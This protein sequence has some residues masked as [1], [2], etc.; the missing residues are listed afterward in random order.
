MDKELGRAQNN[1]DHEWLIV[2][3]LEVREKKRSLSPTKEIPASAESAAQESPVK[4]SKPLEA[5]DFFVNKLKN[6]A[7]EVQG[8][9]T[10]YLPSFDSPIF[11]NFFNV[12]KHDIEKLE[13]K[14]DSIHSLLN[15]PSE[16]FS[17]NAQIISLHPQ[18]NLI[19][20]VE[21]NTPK[22]IKIFDKSTNQINSTFNIL[23]T[24]SIQQIQFLN[25][26]SLLVIATE[27]NNE[28]PDLFFVEFTNG[29]TKKINNNDLEKIGGYIETNA[30]ASAIILNRTYFKVFHT[31]DKSLDYSAQINW[32]KGEEYIFGDFLPNFDNSIITVSTDSVVRWWKRNNTNHAV[33]LWVLF[34]EINLKLP[35]NLSACCA[36]LSPDRTTIAVLCTDLRDKTN[37]DQQKCPA[38]YKHEK[39][40][41]TKAKVCIVD[42]TK[43]EQVH[44]FN[45]Y[46]GLFYCTKKRHK[47]LL[48]CSLIDNENL[49]IK[50]PEQLNIWNFKPKEY[51]LR[52]FEKETTL[53]S[54][55]YNNGNDSCIINSNTSQP[56]SVITQLAQDITAFLSKLDLKC[57]NKFLPIEQSI[58]LEQLHKF[59]ELKNTNKKLYYDL[60]FLL[61]QWIC[62]SYRKGNTELLIP[63]TFSNEM[64]KKLIKFIHPQI[65]NKIHDLYAKKHGTLVFEEEYTKK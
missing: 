21:N 12:N 32:I 54:L 18:G 56:I 52:L 26:H 61:A 15:L 58:F 2:R 53:K 43:Q 59:T 36:T 30:Y 47:E 13:L 55:Q 31:I 28:A 9:I 10:R 46:N 39:Q 50:L 35:A 65:W 3:R 29:R 60:N 44:S 7:Q 17:G 8:L 23:N 42:L 6:N 38:K 63:L 24:K 51:T 1:S 5:L 48:Q 20:Y 16:H 25:K 57:K 49:L 62:Q 34:K 27:I 33:P 22:E 64:V 37:N 11:G 40:L 45:A 14:T 4:K 19:A 41:I